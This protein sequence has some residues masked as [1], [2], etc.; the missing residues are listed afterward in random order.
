M[1]K[2]I[3]REN[4]ENSKNPVIKAG[5]TAKKTNSKNVNKRKLY[6]LL[7]KLDDLRHLEDNKKLWKLGQKL[8]KYG[9]NPEAQ[10]DQQIRALIDE[11]HHSITCHQKYQRKRTEKKRKNT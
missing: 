9:E 1:L 5:K 7:Q 6:P 2:P 8:I 4:P 3:P 10:S 11:V